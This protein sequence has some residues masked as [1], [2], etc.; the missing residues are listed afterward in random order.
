MLI[1]VKQVFV[2]DLGILLSKST[3]DITALHSTA[4]NDLLVFVKEMRN[5]SLIILCSGCCVSRYRCTVS[6]RVDYWV[7]LLLKSVCGREVVV[8][9]THMFRSNF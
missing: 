7:I 6:H 8:R 1:Y 5:C 9:S 4:L 3:A 2:I